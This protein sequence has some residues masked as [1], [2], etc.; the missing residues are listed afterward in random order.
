MSQKDIQFDVLRLQDLMTIIGGT[1]YNDDNA[2][3]W[4]TPSVGCADISTSWS[5]DS[6]ACPF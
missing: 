4:S 2:Q 3:A 1:H 5:T 6:T